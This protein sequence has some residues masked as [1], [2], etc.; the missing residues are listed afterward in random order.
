MQVL[1]ESV[2]KLL[3]L[4]GGDKVTETAQF[5]SL[6]DNFFDCFDVRGFISGKLKWMAFQDPYC[7]ANDFRMKV[8]GAK[9][10][11]VCVH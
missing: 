6:I 1:S 9:V 8:C 7:S 11:V 3:L 10:H 5:I 2:S 4:A